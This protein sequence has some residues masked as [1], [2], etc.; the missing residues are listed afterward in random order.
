MPANKELFITANKEL[1]ITCPAS[2]ETVTKY[3]PYHW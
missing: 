3:N 1:F 2:K